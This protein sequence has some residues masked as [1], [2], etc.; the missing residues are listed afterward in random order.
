MKKTNA[1]DWANLER[2]EKENKSSISSGIVYFGDSITAN[3][4]AADTEFFSKKTY[5][6]RGIGGQTTSQML[7]R[8]RADVIELKPK[9][10]VILAGTND[11]AQ[12]TGPITLDAIVE[13]LIS[14]CELARANAIEVIL[15]SLLPATHYPW[16]P[17]LEPADK[18]ITL[19][20]MIQKYAQANAISYVDYYSDMVNENKGLKS[21]YSK[22]GVHPNK[23]GYRIMRAIIEPIISKINNLSN[24]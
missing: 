22:D 11:I 1:Q 7:L 23:E 9:A 14:M 4:K 13:N 2:Y 19:N 16:K 24:S 5:I 17:E 3:W 10:V 6:N 8:F 12:N 20:G 18:I 21:I 15:C